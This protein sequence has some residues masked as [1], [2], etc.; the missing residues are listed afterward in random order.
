MT[1]YIP[2][3]MN[4]DLVEV[5]PELA[6]LVERLAENNHDVWA[7]NR[8]REGWTFGPNRDDE[9]K[10]NPTLLPYTHLP[11]SEKQYDR[12]TAESSIKLILVHGF[13]LTKLK[14][15]RRPSGLLKK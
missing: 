13:A 1:T 6:A 8:I 2:C 12:D 5:P 4:L 7:E 14:G 11:D 10:T 3:P 15:E 9:K